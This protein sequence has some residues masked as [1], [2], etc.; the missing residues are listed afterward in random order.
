MTAPPQVDGIHFGQE[1][2][3][4]ARAEFGRAR[5][6]GTDVLGQAAAAEAEAGV[7]EAAA[8]PGVVGDGFGQVG[9]V[10]PGDLA[11]FGHGVDE[12]DLGGEEGVGRDLD[13][14]GGRVVDDDEGSPGLEYRS[15]DP[16]QRR[17]GRAIGCHAED[18][19]V[20][21]QGV[22]NREAFPQELGVPGELDPGRLGG[23]PVGE[24]GSGSGRDRGLA[25]DQRTG[26]KPARDQPAD[27]GVDVA[28]VR[29][30]RA[31]VLRCPDT[32]EVDVSPGGS[33][34]EGGRE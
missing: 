3:R 5:L 21:A 8:D 10:G 32:D 26:A 1:L 33:F 28:H 14:L 22:V 34:G 7:Q 6:E 29:R 20:R 31:G 13:E 30:V 23:Q 15:V 24:T 9:D 25:H 11:D 19:P 18:E 16:A 27:S 4:L 2:H 17:L 12:R